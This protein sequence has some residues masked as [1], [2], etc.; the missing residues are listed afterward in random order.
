M[1]NRL[2]LALAGVLL[3]S[4]V[5]RAQQLPLVA[6]PPRPV[7]RAVHWALSAFG[8]VALPPPATSSETVVLTGQ[9]RATWEMNP[10]DHYSVTA[11][12]AELW[13][14]GF[15]VL[16]VPTGPPA[17]TLD[18]GKPLY[19]PFGQIT[20]PLLKPLL[21]PNTELVLFL[22]AINVAGESGLSNALGPL[23]AS[24]QVPSCSD[25]AITLAIQ[26]YSATV[27]VGQ[28][29]HVAYTLANSFPIVTLEV[30]IN[31]DQVVGGQTGTTD[32]RDYEAMGFS[33]PRT[34]GVYSMTMFAKDSQNC[35]VV[36]T[37]PRSI[38][39]Q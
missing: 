7:L 36:T 10:T 13:A 30:R 16:G 28:R 22:R 32:L 34:R 26:S 17:L 9:D 38:T 19:D 20:G 8:S 24:A 1:K 4:S 11:Y 2:R 31:G 15:V 37:A 29:A 14:K 33:M 6:A 25:H 39:V 5:A 18:F 12:R 27:A 35:T 3:A 21:P 23:V